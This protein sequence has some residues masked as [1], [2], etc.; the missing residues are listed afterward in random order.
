MRTNS[1]TISWN[2][3]HP[4][5]LDWGRAFIPSRGPLGDRGRN[6]PSSERREYV[7]VDV[8]A[9]VRRQRTGA[10]DAG[11]PDSAHEVH[12][13]GALRRPSRQMVPEMSATGRRNRRSWKEPARNH[14][15]LIRDDEGSVT[16]VQLGRNAIACFTYARGSEVVSWSRRAAAAC[17]R[18][19]GCG[20]FRVIAGAARRS[21]IRQ[22]VE[23]RTPRRCR[24]SRRRV[25]A[26]AMLTEAASIAPCRWPSARTASGQNRCLQRSEHGGPPH[27]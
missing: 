5:A 26:V 19:A 2:T 27:P 24:P 13:L 22:G 3:V 9:H 12:L 16:Q 11:N 20:T 6:H 1:G 4:E 15:H 14:L 10:P 18:R 21:G 7:E 8:L 17:Q 23:A 25:A